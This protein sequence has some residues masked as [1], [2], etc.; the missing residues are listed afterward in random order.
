MPAC[1][2]KLEPI[3]SI[4]DEIQGLCGHRSELPDCKNFVNELFSIN[5]LT[6]DIYAPA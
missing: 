1:D 5:M 6:V 2:L 3:T 4:F